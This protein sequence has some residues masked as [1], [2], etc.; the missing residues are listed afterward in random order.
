LNRKAFV[1]AGIFLA[2]ALIVPPYLF[3]MQ[4]DADL[5]DIVNQAP[6]L[7]DETQTQGILEDI[8]TQY[9]AIFS[10][11]IATEVIAVILFVIFLWIGLKP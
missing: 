3:N 11:A 10:I 7:A 8:D 6:N 4:H 2:V 5:D 1:V 9:Q